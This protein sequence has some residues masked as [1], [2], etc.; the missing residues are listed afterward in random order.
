MYRLLSAAAGPFTPIL[1]SRRLKRGKE[2][3]QRLP[4]RRGESRIARPEGPLIWLH[5]ASVGELASVLPLIGRIRAGGTGMLITTGT[6]TSGGLAEQRL[7]RGVITNS[8]H[9]IFPG[10]LARFP[11]NCKRIPPWSL[12]PDFCR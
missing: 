12:V 8:F 9:L 4:E 11:T 2:H 3:G 7:H 5:G 6:V 1:L 10:L